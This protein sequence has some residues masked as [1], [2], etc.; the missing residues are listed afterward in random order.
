MT[1]LNNFL[2]DYTKNAYNPCGFSNVTYTTASLRQMLTTNLSAMH[3]TMIGLGNRKLW[4]VG[5]SIS[6]TW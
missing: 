4:V 1:F 2:P 3:F 6:L 5:S